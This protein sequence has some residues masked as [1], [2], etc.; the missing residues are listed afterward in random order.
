MSCD[1]VLSNSSPVENGISINQN[2][3]NRENGLFLLPLEILSIIFNQLDFQSYAI[4]SL[5]SKAWKKLIL[6]DLEQRK[7]FTRVCL[8][9]GTNRTN[10]D[11]EEQE[12]GISDIINELKRKLGDYFKDYF[13][14]PES[15]DW[16]RICWDEGTSWENR[17]EPI[18]SPYHREINFKISHLRVN[19]K[20]ADAF[21]TTKGYRLPR[22]SVNIYDQIVLGIKS[23]MVLSRIG[24][25]NLDSVRTRLSILQ[26][27]LHIPFQDKIN[28]LYR[29]MFLEFILLDKS[30]K[31]VGF[32]ENILPHI[33]D[34]KAFLAQ[35]AEKTVH[36][37]CLEDKYEQA[38]NFIEKYFKNSDLIVSLSRVLAVSVLNG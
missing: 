15:L 7:I 25:E 34:D 21:L 26:A 3:Q 18:C 33:Q 4:G 24:L 19:V 17:D 14:S 35:V 29:Q 23:Q 5:V 9:L 10:L 16:K 27:Q 11:L 38:S 22:L 8:L 28:F 30:D 6:E 36:H 12:N 2:P 13:Y 31:S 20:L 37:L 1:L 32:F